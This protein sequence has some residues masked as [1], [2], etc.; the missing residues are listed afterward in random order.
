MSES[1]STEHLEGT[2]VAGERGRVPPNPPSAQREP[3]S[4]Y[5]TPLKGVTTEGAAQ[6]FCRGPQERGMKKSLDYQPCTQ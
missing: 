6:Y 5:G 2:Q 4:T 3:T 1:I